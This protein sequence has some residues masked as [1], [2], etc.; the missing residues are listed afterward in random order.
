MGRQR[1]PPNSL[2][3]AKADMTQ[4]FVYDPV[5]LDSPIEVCDLGAAASW[6]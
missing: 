1:A 3:Q 5:I 4:P 6:N 2:A